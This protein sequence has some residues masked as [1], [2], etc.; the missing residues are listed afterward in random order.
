VGTTATIEPSGVQI[1]ATRPVSWSLTSGVNPSTSTFD[2]SLQNVAALQAFASGKEPVSLVIDSP[3][4]ARL[5]IHQ[6]WIMDFPPADNPHIGRVQ[7]GDRRWFWPYSHVLRRYNI[8]RQIGNRRLQR[9]DNVEQL[10]PNA[11]TI[12]YAAW[13]LKQDQLPPTLDNRWL[14]VDIIQDVLNAATRMEK[15]YSFKFQPPVGLTDPDSIDIMDGVTVEN[16]EIDASG[17]QAM[18]QA[19]ATLPGINCYCDPSGN[20]HLYSVAG[21]GDAHMAN[22]MLPEVVGGGHAKKVSNQF[23]RPSEIRVLYTREHEL[24]FDYIEETQIKDAEPTG[25]GDQ[26][27]NLRTMENV[28]AIPDF[29]LKV[30]KDNVCQG[31]W[32]GIPKVLDAWGSPFTGVAGTAIQYE[33]ILRAFVPYQDIWSCLG[34]SGK[35]DIDADWPPRIASLQENFR[36]TFR[37]NPTWW[38][39]MLSL[40][41][42]RLSVIDPVHGTRAPATVYSGYAIVP[43]LRGFLKR[44]DPQQGGTPGEKFAYF[45]N[46]DGYPK[47][48]DMDN[49]GS[50]FTENTKVA[51]ARVLIADPEQGI[52]SFQYKIDPYRTMEMILPS[53]IEA[54]GGMPQ[55]DPTSLEQPLT[56]DILKQDDANNPVKEI[57]LSADCKVAVV[58]TGIP[59][60]PNTSEQLYQVTV[61]PDD[62][63]DLLSGR[64]VDTAGF[65]LSSGPPLEIRVGQGM[66]TAMVAWDDERAQDIEKAFGLRAFEQL[67]GGEFETVNTVLKGLVLNDTEED[68]KDARV[69]SLK[70][71][72]QAIAADAYAKRLDRIEGDMTGDLF[73]GVTPSG[74]LSNVTHTLSQDGSAHTKVTFPSAAVGV[75]VYQFLPAST[76][77]LLMRQVQKF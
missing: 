1:L 40:N 57:R 77:R 73:L 23:T 18:A 27:N 19:M 30:G 74:W 65:G 66:L 72:A 17:E 25:V 71:L 39:R 16:L 14:P 32:I 10:E 38:D 54:D 8:R 22:N 42:T 67:P 52:I 68:P 5:A 51:P 44:A 61:R 21:G 15:E 53:Q 58:L 56:W 59:A 70:I 11:Q 2:I 34:L 63:K 26:Q 41:A 60:S 62:V 64:S 12:A 33:L 75:D 36:R 24:R 69:A 76:R 49:G 43:G 46:V 6:L 13:S 4:H 28:L 47:G 3:G 31:T 20:I 37:I 29:E 55:C 50:K 45:I 9:P 35:V 48:A 7:L